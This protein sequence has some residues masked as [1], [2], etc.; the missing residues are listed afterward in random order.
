MT[1]G[2]TGGQ[3]VARTLRR[4]GAEIIF[5]VSGNQ[6]L[7]VYDAAGDA[8]LRIIHMRHESAAA[9]AAAAHA[10]LTGQP[11]VALTSAGPGFLAGLTG[12]AVARSMELPLLYLSGA[13]PLALRNMGAFQD[14][15]QKRIGMTAWC[16]TQ[17]ARLAGFIRTGN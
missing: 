15:D 8:G 1:A 5:S 11:G 16:E 12:V 13:A 3:I 10:E 17:K 7:P 9:Y 6:V 4:L 2:A 14:L